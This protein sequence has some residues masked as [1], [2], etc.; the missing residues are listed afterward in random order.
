MADTG[1]GAA[2]TLSEDTNS[3]SVVSISPGGL[4]VES[5]DVSTLASS[6]QMEYIP[7]DLADT[8]EVS[9]EILFEVGT[10]LPT[11]GSTHTITVT[12]PVGPEQTT[13]TAATLAGTGFVTAVE[14][15]ELVNN[16]VQRSNITLKF[17]GGHDSGTAAT[18][19]AGS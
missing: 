6:S 11:V 18:F 16:Q 4:S 14:Y 8:P 17:N 3:Y 19:T 10:G 1:N 5:L 7:G 2:L 9:A 12:F 15:P 13:T